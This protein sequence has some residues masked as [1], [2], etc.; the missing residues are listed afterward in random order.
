MDGSLFLQNRRKAIL[1]MPLFVLSVNAQHVLTKEYHAPRAGD[2]LIK[3]Q[4]EYTS[5]GIEGES[6]CW[7]FSRVTIQNQR[8]EVQWVGEQDTIA[9]VLPHAINL[10]QIRQDSTQTVLLRSRAYRYRYPSSTKSS[11]QLFAAPRYYWKQWSAYTGNNQ[12]EN[13]LGL[14]LVNFFMRAAAFYEPDDF[15]IQAG[16]MLPEI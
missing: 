13:N 5:S 1:L 15:P 3:Q 9:Q 14:F 7:D 12:I 11:G 8:F 6:I 2:R 4:M 10:V 16:H